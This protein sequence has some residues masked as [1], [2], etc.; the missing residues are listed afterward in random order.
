MLTSIAIIIATKNRPVEIER[1]LASMHTQTH[2]PAEVLVIDQ[3]ARPY[4]LRAFPQLRHVYEPRLSG[5]AAARNFGAQLSTADILLFIDDDVE[6]LP[7]TLAALARAFDA[8]PDAIGMQCLDELS[9]GDR[10]RLAEALEF[11]FDRGPFMRHPYWRDGVEYRT[12]LSGYAMAF[13][14]RL[15]DKERLDDSLLGYSYG[16][17]WEFSQRA[18]RYGTLRIASGAGVLHHE[19]STNREQQSVMLL[20][21]WINFHYFFHKLE[22]G[23]DPRNRLWLAWWELGECYRWLR[24][25]MG[26]PSRR[27]KLAKNQFLMPARP[28]P[29]MATPTISGD[30][31]IAAVE[32]VTLGQHGFV[33]AGVGDDVPARSPGSSVASLES[34]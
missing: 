31:V 2:P 16:E 26:L 11:L 6:L 17:D 10:G 14:S 7:G 25:G 30:T 24:A 32:P 28:A 1:C 33:V 8:A 15:F 23:R 21:R 9:H 5:A 18:R 3:S 12:W 20:H 34:A 29:P 13:R 4:S 22:A 19:S 27:A